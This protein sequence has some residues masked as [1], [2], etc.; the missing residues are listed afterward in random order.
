M[1]PHKNTVTRYAIGLILICSA[2]FFQSCTGHYSVQG[3]TAEDGNILHNGRSEYFIGTNLW[4]AGRLA[5]D[6]SGRERLGR[7]LDTLKA[8]GITNLRV[9][10]T[11]GEDTDGLRYALDRMQERGM[12]AVLFLN[13][14]W[15]WSYGYSDYLEKAGAG[16]QPRPSTDGYPA[17][18]KAMG[19]YC[20]NENAVALN[21][22]YIRSVVTELKDHPAIFSWQ[23]CNEPRCFSDDSATKDAFVGY[24][25]STAALIKSIDGRHMVSTGNEGTKGC[26][27]DME[28]C[29]RINDCPD[30]DYMTIHIWPYNWGWVKE[31]SLN[32]SIEAATA[33]VGEYIDRH[34]HLAYVL[35]KPMVIEEFGYPR[36]G[37]S[38]DRVSTTEG[39]DRIYGYVF[40]RVIRSASE[41]GRLAGCN[42]WGWGGYAEPA[43]TYWEE[44]D[45][46]CGDPAQEQ[47]GLNS[48]FATDSSTIDTIAKA[49]YE[50]ESMTRLQYDFS[51]GCLFTGGEERNLSVSVYN[52]SETDVRVSM[53]LVSD[54]SLMENARDTVLCRVADVTDSYACL[55][56]NLNGVEPGFYQV[57]LAWDNGAES[58]TYPSFNIGIDPEMIVS[59]QDRRDDFD[60]F[61]STTLS[62][63]AGTPMIV[64]K[65]FSP[66]HSN[67]LRNS[68]RV[69]ITSW[70]GGVMGGILCEPAAAGK[71]PVYVDYMGYGAQYYWYDPSADPEAVEFLVSVRDQ[72]IFK[73]NQDRWIDR[74]IES[75]ENFYY[76][77][78]FCDVVRAV[79]FV[80]SLEKAD[81]TRIFAR[82]ESQGG[83]FT[84]IAAALDRR[85]AAAAPAVPFLCDFNDYS[86]IVWWPVWEIFESADSQGISRDALFDTLSYFDIKNFTDRIECPVFMAF[87]LQ[88]PTCP[89]HTNFAGYNMIAS[90]KDY[91]CVPSC[92]HAMWEEKSWTSARKDFFS[93]FM[94]GTNHIKYNS[95]F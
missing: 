52:P 43:H 74:G 15:E 40:S 56:F 62:E 76:R 63:L 66:E 22:E 36:D 73:G 65:E 89:P 72:G 79:D 86:H 41:N 34:L 60:G 1:Q 78:A 38:F 12:S 35:R 10:A 8:L 94:E 9:L 91:F 28:L 17:Y 92:G 82:G 37:F 44:G 50:L 47:Q 57:N 11:E 18:M 3:W 21:H 39:R 31:D 33:Q 24:I 16:P 46:L 90:Q 23:I 59:P 83:A 87:G 13:N 51:T 54:L 26:E 27:E 64:R 2:L 4:Y 68:Y 5:A 19:A 42:F 77:G 61:W 93:R 25:H 29:R 80:S 55:K 45:D 20:G 75:K 7:E 32:D 81:T 53:A 14:A 6:E 48:V 70:N 95:K 69:E 85:I 30:I 71:Y 67:E 58:G 88:D 84:L 49:T